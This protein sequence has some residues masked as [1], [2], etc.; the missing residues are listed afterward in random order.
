MMEDWS[1]VTV[2]CSGMMI[3]MVLAKA[4]ISRTQVN[5]QLTLG[6][7]FNNPMVSYADGFASF[8]LDFFIG[9]AISS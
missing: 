7:I 9:K 6:G 5:D 2:M 3:G 8:D 1:H 4:I